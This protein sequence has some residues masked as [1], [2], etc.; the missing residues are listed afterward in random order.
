MPNLHNQLKGYFI[1]SEKDIPEKYMKKIEENLRSEKEEKQIYS[2]KTTS[3]KRG[4]VI[5]KESEIREIF[6]NNNELYFGHGTP[7]GEDVVNSILEI[8]LKA[9]DPEIV[10][11]YMD[12]LRGLS[13]TTFEWGEGRNAMFDKI[14]DELDNWPHKESDNIIIVSAPKEYRLSRIAEGDPYEAF[15]I[16]NEEKGYYVRPEFIKGVYN[17]NTHSFTLNENF[18]R[19]LSEEKQL[20]LF[21]EVK[22][23]FIKAYAKYAM[24]SPE[25]MKKSLP[26]NEIE[27]EQASVEWYKVQLERLKMSKIENQEIEEDEEIFDS[28][29]VWLDLEEFADNAKISDFEETTKMMNNDLQPEKE[30]KENTEEGWSVEDDW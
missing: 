12:T 28:D 17:S 29:M 2:E 5:S 10:R 15:Y 24:C 11:M 7:G 22:Q 1:E 4:K 21:K 19:N 30:E 26:L 27:L 9:K 3:G 16:G 8:G 18:Y 14:K 23:R 20:N 6:N 25:E 13:S